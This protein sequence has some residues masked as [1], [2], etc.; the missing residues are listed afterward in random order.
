MIMKTVIF[1]KIATEAALMQLDIMREEQGNEA[2]FGD[3]QHKTAEKQETIDKG[4]DHVDQHMMF[5]TTHWL[6]AEI[7]TKAIDQLKK[8]IVNQSFDF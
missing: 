2:K 4:Q 3:A 7:L 6:K 1:D 8:D 5:A